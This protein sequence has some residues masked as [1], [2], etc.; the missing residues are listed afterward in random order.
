MTTIAAEPPTTSMTLL[1]AL[2]AVVES[3][4]LMMVA[5]LAKFWLDAW[6]LN[7]AVALS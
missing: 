1:D 5:S 3:S 2:V 4:L 7:N 6:E